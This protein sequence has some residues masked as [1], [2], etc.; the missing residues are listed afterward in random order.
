M[1]SATEPET[2]GIDTLSQT[3]EFI[4]SNIISKVKNQQSTAQRPLLLTKTSIM[5]LISEQIS[6]QGYTIEPPKAIKS[7]SGLGPLF[8]T[9]PQ[10]LRDIIF[11]NCLSSGHPQFLASSRAMQTQGLAQLSEKAV[12]RLNIGIGARLSLI[13][14]TMTTQTQ[15]CPHNMPRTVPSSK[16]QHLSIRIKA[17]ASPCLKFWSSIDLDVLEWFTGDGVS[18]QSCKIVFELDYRGENCLGDSVLAVLK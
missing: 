5:H 1:A 7:P 16:I 4:L 12:F 8:Q 18:R 10:E 15:E 14:G 2:I 3:F 17:T 9:L 6:E 13:F 11:A